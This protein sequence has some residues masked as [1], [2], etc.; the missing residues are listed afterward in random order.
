ML[1]SLLSFELLLNKRY[2]LVDCKIVLVK[3]PF[4]SLLLNLSER[5]KSFQAQPSLGQNEPESAKKTFSR[6]DKKCRI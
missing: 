3:S 2:I 6:I 4:Y 5:N 1:I